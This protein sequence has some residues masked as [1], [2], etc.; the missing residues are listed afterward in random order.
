LVQLCPSTVMLLTEQTVAIALA[1]LPVFLIARKHLGSPRAALGFSLAYLL[2]PPVQ[3][4]TLNEFHPVALACPLLLY[5]FWYLDEDRLVPFAVFAVLAAASKEEV[6][7]VIAGM[8]LWYA[9]AHGRRAAGGAIALLGAAASV[10]AIEVVVPHFNGAASN[11]YSRYTDVGGSPGGVVKTLFTHPLRVLKT[12][13]DG[14][15]LHYLGQ[16]LVPLGGL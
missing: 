8:G 6:G 5:A 12:A 7:L 15:G 2:Y 9:L 4:L 10:I 11:F 14:R 3:W 16:L 1:A 13:F